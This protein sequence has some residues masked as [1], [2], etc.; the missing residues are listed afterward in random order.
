MEKPFGMR[1]FSK[2]AFRSEERRK[3]WVVGARQ[4]VERPVT[5]SVQG[6]H[7]FFVGQSE[8]GR[9]SESKGFGHL[10]GH[11]R[12]ISFELSTVLNRSWKPFE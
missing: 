4:R 3:G 11:S 9:I 12:S 8:S 7:F 6:E 5:A 10:L 2:G 1:T